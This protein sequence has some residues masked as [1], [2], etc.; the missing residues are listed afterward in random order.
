MKFQIHSIIRV[1]SRQTQLAGIVLLVVLATTL[2]S[3][4]E[5]IG[6][7]L[8][9][10]FSKSVRD[11]EKAFKDNTWF[12]AAIHWTASE[13]KGGIETIVANRAYFFQGHNYMR[14]NL[15]VD[16]QD[17]GLK[18]I[19]AGWE[20]PDDSRWNNGIDAALCWNKR[21]I[22]YLFKDH[23]YLRY[24][25]RTNKIEGNQPIT[26]GWA[27]NVPWDD[28]VDA[29]VYWRDDRAMF[30]S[31]SR[32]WSYDLANDTCSSVYPIS[33]IFPNIP[34]S[35]SSDIDSALNGGNGKIY[36]FKGDQ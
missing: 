7:T 26:R 21:Q 4:A 3:S 13:N 35:F 9:R 11:T 10:V 33:R 5:D 1:S 15:W 2:S 19:T 8:N 18:N 24:N 30:F 29:A 6:K 22:A 28:G 25:M 31:G 32:Y 20:W 12:D 27:G 14:Y 16:E 23:Y 36:L 34:S 17:Q